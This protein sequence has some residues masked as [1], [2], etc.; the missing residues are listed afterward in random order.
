[1]FRKASPTHYYHLCYL[2][3]RGRLEGCYL[4][5]DQP[6]TCHDSDHCSEPGVGQIQSSL[7]WTVCPSRSARGSQVLNVDPIGIFGSLWRFKQIQVA[8]VVWLCRAGAWATTAAPLVKKMVK[9]VILWNLLVGRASRDSVK[10]PYDSALN[11][12]PVIRS[13][14]PPKHEIFFAS[15]AHFRKTGESKPSFQFS[16]DFVQP[17]FFGVEKTNNTSVLMFLMRSCG[18][19]KKCQ[20]NVSRV[21]SGCGASDDS[22]G[23]CW[24][25]LAR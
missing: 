17:H 24:F 12:P 5:P 2:P 18:A 6:V 15:P 16:P 23:L 1:M 25:C 3:L 13:Q 22:S 10:T 21:L 20:A 9:Q 14:Q 11:N 4:S 7:C 19:K 8:T